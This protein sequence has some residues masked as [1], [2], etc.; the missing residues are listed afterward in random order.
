MANHLQH[1][2]SPYLKQHRNNPVDWYPWGDEALNKAQEE[3][4]LLIV[5]IGYSACHWCHVMERESFENMK[6]AEVMNTG[7]IAIKVDREE[8]PD[9][10]QL[11]MTAVQLMTNS[12]GW[13]LNCICLPDGRPI[14]GGTYFRPADWINT[15]EQVQLLWQNE[16]KTAVEYAE[17]LA[18]GIKESENFKISRIPEAYGVNDLLAIVEPWR[19]TFDAEFG[20]YQ[21]APKFPLP[22]NWLFFLRYGFL[23]NDQEILNHTHFTLQQI[24]S[25]GIYDHIGGGF[26]RYSV[27]AKWHIPHFEKM[28][29]DN[30]QLVS[31]YTEAYLQREN[32]LYR[33][34]IE[35]T[36]GWVAREMT[37]P[38]GGF[39]SALDADSEGVEGK[40]YTFDAKELEKVLADDASLFSS[41]FGVSTSGNWE[42]EGTN[43]LKTA[44]GADKLAAEAG[45]VGDEW[46]NYLKEI[47]R[48]LLAYRELRERPGLDDKILTSWNA[49]MLKAYVDAYQAFNNAE[50]LVI[51][52]RNASYILKQLIAENGKLLH[53]PASHD[54]VIYGFLDDYAFSIEAFVA[55]YEATFQIDWLLKAKQLTDYVIAHFFDETKAAF[56]YTADDAEVLI[57]RKF[58][59]MDNVIPASNSVMVHQLHKLGLLFDEQKYAQISAQLM[60]NIF[61]QLKSYGSAYSNWSIRLLETVYGFNEI[62]ITGPEY[63]ALHKTVNQCYIPNKV[64]LGGQQENLPLL[65]GRVTASNLIYV[66]KNN[67]CSLPVSSIADM[68]K[69]IFEPEIKS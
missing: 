43:V 35:E 2:T 36:L 16:P 57:T 46:E 18:H 25:G 6:V 47:K 58:E 37:S 54:K 5:S 22:N 24:A 40:F 20:G 44:A 11:Y 67:T 27:D 68:K 66:C 48:K 53:Q 60:A 34:V 21:R 31:L 19:K 59:L 7:F 38:E 65:K 39:Y 4:K 45:F 9:I 61:P 51:A 32:P 30:A 63:Q 33:R 23:A 69:L 28:L 41:Y 1:E 15:L 12:G 49:M 14:Y 17:K 62:A 3:N 26:S 56:Y 29:Y 13:P 52:E 55:L 42:E 50:Y 64:L 10:D 8:R